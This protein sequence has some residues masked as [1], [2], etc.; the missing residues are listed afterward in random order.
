MCLI[1]KHPWFRM[2]V[3]NFL[4]EYTEISNMLATRIIEK[5][6]IKNVVCNID[7]VK[8]LVN[9]TD[10]T[11]L[12]IVINKDKC[13]I[14]VVMFQLRDKYMPIRS[15]V[16]ELKITTQGYAQYNNIFINL[17]HVKISEWSINKLYLDK[18]IKLT[19]YYTYSFNTHSFNDEFSDG[20]FSEN[21][22][23]V[24]WNRKNAKS[25]KLSEKNK[26]NPIIKTKIRELYIED[27][28]INL[29]VISHMEFDVL[30][31]KQ[32][33]YSEIEEAFKSNIPK[34][35]YAKDKKLKIPNH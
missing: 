10:A 33:T 34:V 13:C 8:H 27:D 4:A 15:K 7:H 3:L 1:R 11:S 35:I 21:D 18:G 6:H 5:K 31:L 30:S 23:Q 17:D 16:K 22:D 24:L 9:L 20:D 19:D 26:T 29:E 12:T 32:H 2:L 14:N 25:M 28:I